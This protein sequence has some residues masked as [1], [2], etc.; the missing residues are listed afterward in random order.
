MQD[1]M[2]LLTDEERQPNKIYIVELHDYDVDYAYGYFNDYDKAKECRDYLNK[3][4]P[5]H[6]ADCDCEW[7]IV[8]YSFNETDYAAL[9]KAYEEEQKLI[10]EQKEEAFRQTELAELARLKAKYEGV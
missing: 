7:E 1:F 9:L 2:S 10:A 3:V 4:E 8:S 5:S 6:Y